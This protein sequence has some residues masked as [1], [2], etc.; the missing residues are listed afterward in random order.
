MS[1]KKTRWS[2]LT[3]IRS[4]YQYLRGGGVWG[5]SALYSALGLGLTVPGEDLLAQASKRP[6]SLFLALEKQESRDQEVHALAV[7]DRPV[8]DRVGTQDVPE[9][10]AGK[11][12]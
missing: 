5:Y 8:P 3:G 12:C 10:A 1:S 4:R 2:T 6:E 7:P 9:A 11:W